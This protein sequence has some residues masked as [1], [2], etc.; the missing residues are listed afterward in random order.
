MY[1]EIGSNFWLN[2]HEQLDDTQINLDFLDIKMKDIAYLSTGRSAISFVLDNI[3]V[4]RDEKKALLPPF[5]CHTVIQPFIN[6]GY[7]IS[8]YR[9]NKDLSIDKKDFLENVKVYQPSVI[10]VH[11]Y[12]GFNTLGQINDIIQEIRDLGTIIIEDITQTLYSQ[13]NHIS[14]DYYIC[15]FRKWTALPDG[16]CA[17]STNDLFSY[18]PT[19]VDY[20]LEESKLN[21]FHSKYLYMD[22]NIGEKNNFLKLFYDAEQI[23]NK[24]E[25]IYAMGDVSKK[26]QSNLDIGELRKSRQRNYSI[27]N[28]SLTNSRIVEPVF[29]ELLEEVT[30]L[31][32][33]IYVKC[34]RKAFQTYLA[35]NKIYAPIIWPKSD[36]CN[37][38]INLEV[39]WIYRNILSIPCDQRYSMEDMERVVEIINNYKQSTEW[40]ER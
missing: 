35:E 24:Q 21:A 20:R 15:S 13:F 19:N 11:G 2:R 39:D 5:T 23:L 29:P 17:I 34:D 12:F 40:Y 18:K 8:F 25:S 27:L 26:L 9:I 28:E 7:K 30:P 6:A 1:N 3:E 14:A 36:L 38:S 32:F 31:Y 10:L 22:I 37:N 16:G 33:P 4:L